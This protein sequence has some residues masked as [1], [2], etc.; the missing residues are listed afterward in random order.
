MRREKPT[1]AAPRGPFGDPKAQPAAA[2]ASPALGLEHRVGVSVRGA[3]APLVALRSSSRLQRRLELVTTCVP[4]P[5][6]SIA[7]FRLLEIC[8]VWAWRVTRKGFLGCATT[9]RQ[10]EAGRELP[11]GEGS[12][13]Q[14]LG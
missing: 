3:A 1:R 13:R 4:A 10:W 9:G 2:A 6:N 8:G 14:G 11:E 7:L 5:P 12:R